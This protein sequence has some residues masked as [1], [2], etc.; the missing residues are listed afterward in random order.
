M[1]SQSPEQLKEQ[2]N[3]LF[4]EGDF[5]GALKVY[6]E[7]TVTLIDDNQNSSSKILLGILYANQ[8][9]CH[10]KLHDWA[11]A[12]QA[13]NFALLVDPGNIKAKVRKLQAL[14][15]LDRYD[16]FLTLFRGLDN[17]SMLSSLANISSTVIKQRQGVYDLSSIAFDPIKQRQTKVQTYIGPLDMKETAAMGRGLFLTQT[18][19]AGKLLL[20]EM[21]VIN[22]STSSG[23]VKKGDD[24]KGSSDCDSLRQVNIAMTQLQGVISKDSTM[25]TKLSWLYREGNSTLQRA[26]DIRWYL[27]TWHSS[28]LQFPIDDS[29]GSSSCCNLKDT[30]LRALLQGNQFGTESVTESY[31]SAFVRDSLTRTVRFLCDDMAAVRGEEQILRPVTALQSMIIHRSDNTNNSTTSLLDNATSATSVL[32]QQAVQSAIVSD[33][34]NIADHL[35]CTALHYAVMLGDTFAVQELVAHASK[36]NATA[37]DRLGF[38]AFHYAAA[39]YFDPSILRMLLSHE[40]KIDVNI[41]TL[42]YQTPLAL[43]CSCRQ[44]D[45][46]RML[47]DF[48]ADPTLGH[49]YPLLSACPL[50]E[51][52]ET[53]DMELLRLFA[54]AGYNP[55][56]RITALRGRRTGL[57]LW[58]VT[59][60]CNHS[61]TPNTVRVQVGDLMLIYADRDLKIGQEVFIRYSRDRILLKEK[62]HVG[63]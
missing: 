45:A 61:E 43:A 27:P 56:E 14:F 50:D 40:C 26:P 22:T 51:A 29:N 35:G 37:L 24:E 57:G 33:D 8:A 15:E 30:D 21:A 23:D 28:Y 6:T 38:S 62:W 49:P 42:Q 1:I 54:A 59:S 34:I 60:F 7:A 58:L 17:P 2:G 39:Q 13:C 52:I 25:T 48:G 4:K 5:T 44:L 32:L 9:L 20:A 55:I 53:R 47:L 3:V 36:L 46:V 63:L 18:V 16:E 19:K 31:A 11:G 41:M 10:L 12:L